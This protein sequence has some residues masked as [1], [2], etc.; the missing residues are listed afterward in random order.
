MYTL[1]DILERIQPTGVFSVGV[2]TVLSALGLL[3][4]AFFIFVFGQSPGASVS[5]DWV[6][7]GV[8][9]FG[10]CGAL[11]FADAVLIFR[12]IRIGYYLSMILWVLTFGV[13]VWWSYFLGLFN[14]DNFV[15]L[16]GLYFVYYALYSI[17]CFVYFM[18]SNVRTYFGNKKVMP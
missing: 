12:G 9:L 11:Y 6:I 18:R 13:D 8:G 5:E 1:G 4:A 7:R 15:S 14:A 17:V 3:I 10:G 2:L 16:V